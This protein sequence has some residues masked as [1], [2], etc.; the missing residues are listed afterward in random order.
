MRLEADTFGRSQ[1]K[2]AKVG[3]VL[4]NRASQTLR[5]PLFLK[6]N[7]IASLRAGDCIVTLVAIPAERCSLLPMTITTKE[8]I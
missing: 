5:R 6:I 1:A 3:V 7:T 4:L 2:Q 8:L